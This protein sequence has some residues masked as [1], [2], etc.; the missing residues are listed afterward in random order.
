MVWIEDM[1]IL[2]IQKKKCKD[3]RKLKKERLSML[4]GNIKRRETK[5]LS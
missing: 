3:W 2:D 4:S 5:A 1:R